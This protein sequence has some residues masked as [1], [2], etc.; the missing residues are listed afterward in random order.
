MAH[1]IVKFSLCSISSGAKL[2]DLIAAAID[3]IADHIAIPAELIAGRDLFASTSD[4]FASTGD[5]FANPIAGI[6]LPHS[7]W[8]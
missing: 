5:P 4:P 3:P 2:A 6:I 7:Q 1:S 8:N